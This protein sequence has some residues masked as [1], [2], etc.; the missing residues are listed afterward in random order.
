MKRMITQ[1]NLSGSMPHSFFPLPAILD[2]RGYEVTDSVK[3]RELEGKDSI[4]IPTDDKGGKTMQRSAVRDPRQLPSDQLCDRLN[5]VARLKLFAQAE[6]PVEQ[7]WLVPQLRHWE[8]VHDPRDPWVRTGGH[9]F[10]LISMRF[11]YGIFQS[12]RLEWRIGYDAYT[13]RLAELRL[14]D[15]YG[16]FVEQIKAIDFLDWYT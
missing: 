11:N 9:G 8:F 10:A 5:D 3:R 14:F 4:W 16:T 15:A 12:H 6:K 2:Y 13:Q 7:L 1:V